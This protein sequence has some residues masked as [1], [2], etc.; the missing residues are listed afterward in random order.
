V[1]DRCG[2]WYLL[3]DLHYQ[4]EWRGPRL[5]NI[6]LRVC[7]KCYDVPFIFNRPLVIPP[8]PVPRYDPRPENFT[9]ADE[10]TFPLP[11]LPWPV[12][13]NGPGDPNA[14]PPPVFVTPQV[15]PYTSEPSLPPPFVPPGI[16]P[17]VSEP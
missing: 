13:Q 1:C 8:D 15:E 12:Q 7:Q 16:E 5:M 17:L 14:P 9:Q 6:R 11:P 4:M 10:G 2:F 3:D